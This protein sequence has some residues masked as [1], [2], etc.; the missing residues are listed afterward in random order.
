M[1]DATALDNQTRSALADFRALLSKRYGSRLR[2]LVLFGS[3]ARGDHRPDSDADVA[4]FIGDS[5][6]PICEQMDM[7]DEAYR[8][9]LDDGLLIQPWVFKGSPDQ[10]DTS[11]AA[12]LLKAVQDEGVRL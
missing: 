1:R 6:D 11:H 7:A 10:P 5:D 4:V 9:F 2:G 3:R 8:V 12:N